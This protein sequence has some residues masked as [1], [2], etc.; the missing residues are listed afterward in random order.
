MEPL[1]DTDRLR[2]LNALL[3]A[4][5]NLPP[6]GRDAWLAQLGPEHLALLPELRSL[7][8][9]AHV[10]TDDFL[11]KGAHELLDVRALRVD[12]AGDVV[13]PYRLI[14]ELGRGGMSTVWR[15]ERCDGALQ[16]EVALKLPHAGWAYSIAQRMALERDILA[17]LEHA[18]IAR[19]YDAGLTAEG[20]PWLAMECVRGLPLDRYCRERRLSIAARLD[21]FLQVTDAVAYAH[22]RLVVHRDLK[23]SNIL[24]TTDGQ[25]RLLDFGVAKL[26]EDDGP[27][28]HHLTRQLG[29]PVTPDYAAPELLGT[30]TVGTAADTYSLGIV[31]F[32]LLTGQRPYT[33]GARGVAALEESVLRAH[34]PLVS[35]RVPD[36]VT[37]RALRGDLDAIVD[38]ALRKQ[39]VD[40]YPS[41]E[42]FAADIRRHLDGRPVLAQALHWRYRTVKF[43]RRFRVQLAVATTVVASLVAGLGVALWQASVA[44]QETARAE[45]TKRFVTSILERAQPRQGTGGAVLASDLLAVAGG[46][47]ESELE[48]DPQ[49][50][51]ELGIVVGAGLSN[52]GDPQRGEQPLRAAVARA[53]RVFGP[54]H[55]LTIHGR[56]LLAESLSI[57]KPEEAARIA[58]ELVPDALAGLPATAVDAVFALRSQSFQL[59]KR[60]L[61]EASYRPL[62]QAVALSEQHLG[63]LHEETVLTLGL[64]SNTYGRFGEHQLQLQAAEDARSRAEASLGPL[65]PNV[66]LT[67]VERW[68]AEALRSTNRPADA[69]PIL[70]RVLKDQRQL[71]GSDTERVRNAIFQLG[72]ALAETGELGEALTL[73]RETVAMESRQNSVDNEDRRD[74]RA[75]L[76]GVLGYARRAGE[77]KSLMDDL[78]FVEDIKPDSTSLQIVR[79]LRYA[80]MLAFKGEAGAA[81]EL[82]RRDARDIAATHPSLRAEAWSIASVNA[83]LQRKASE[84]H[85]LAQ[86]AWDEPGRPLLR[87]S[88]QA[89]IAA[90]LA[91]AVL[92][93]G[94]VERAESLVQQALALFEQGQVTPSPRSS[95]AWILRAR[96]LLREGRGV[97]AQRVLEPVVRAWQSANP[98]SAWH[99][100]A[101]FWSSQALAQMGRTADARR[102]LHEARTMLQ[103]SRLPAFRALAALDLQRH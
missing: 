13:G 14:E 35:S 66:T 33:L 11:R 29:R 17:S 82:A 103:G 97:E 67:A 57:Q 24:V 46:R 94:D 58:D 99:G 42:A 87:A 36:R 31:L 70:R 77:A 32:E 38:K 89:V 3:E 34:V 101:L 12:A 15:A 61:A 73:M 50:A 96:L 83:R 30:R 20:R 85:R 81:D 71:D 90:E 79:S 41:V 88:G 91:A 65:R 62:K 8:A 92:D 1:P 78:G 7:I 10:E 37:Q 100:E 40:R 75:A 6:E 45:R 74:Y 76:A 59:A 39:P 2:Q 55:P 86:R 69:V 49:A 27:G 43:V 56:A 95:P 23:P 4:A 54:R 63:R 51:A 18:R 19:L 22:A 68:Y 28:E 25:V 16:R 44:R 9:R 5:L 102:Q 26:M 52:L 60:D 80:Q 48:S 64:L 21:L 98:G 84:A 72:L 47:I 93:Q 53:Q